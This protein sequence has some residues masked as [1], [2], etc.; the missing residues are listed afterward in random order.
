MKPHILKIALAL[1]LALN[2]SVLGAAGL[3]LVRGKGFVAAEGSAVAESLRLDD[4]Q[5]RQWTE[6]ENG[7]KDDFRESWDATRRH[8]ETLIRTI[9]SDRPDRKTIESERRAIL[10]LLAKQQQR[11]IAQ[12]LVKRDMLNEEQRVALAELLIN[13]EPPAT[14]SQLLRQE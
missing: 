13:Q 4:E 10:D 7:F 6:M 12:L 8:R 11:I 14:V 3:Q 2:V 1:S 5:R 9:F